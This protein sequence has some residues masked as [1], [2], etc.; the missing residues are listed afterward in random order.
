MPLWNHGFRVDYAK[1]AWEDMPME[2]QAKPGSR[3]NLGLEHNEDGTAIWLPLLAERLFAANLK[4][5][6]ESR[7]MTQAALAR[8]MTLRD[9]P[10]SQSAVAKLEREDDATRRPLRLVEAAALAG[11]F[12]RSIDDMV[13]TLVPTDEWHARLLEAQRAQQDALQDQVAAM[14]ALAE[15]EAAVE[16]ASSVVTAIREERD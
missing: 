9:V 4:Q 15:A 14:Q 8:Q 6:R 1:L 16:A 5:E 3:F 13:T 10:L 12:H 2:N 11:F 7:R